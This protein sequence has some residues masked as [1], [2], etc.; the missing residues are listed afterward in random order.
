MRVVTNFLDLDTASDGEW[1]PASERA[2]VL[3]ALTETPHNLDARL[4]IDTGA[5]GL[6]ISR[7]VADHAGL[8]Q[9]S[10]T[11]VGGVGSCRAA[12]TR[13]QSIT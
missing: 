12:L 4:Q 6:L 9:F 7:S 10:R 11:E 8:K 1:Q 3:A 13:G 5:S 2:V